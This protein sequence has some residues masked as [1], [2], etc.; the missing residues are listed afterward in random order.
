MQKVSPHDSIL[1]GSDAWIILETNPAWNL[2]DE[3]QRYYAEYVQWTGTYLINRAINL[4]G[5]FSDR[6]DSTFT[7]IEVPNLF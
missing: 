2:T 7:L 1:D 3:T 4:I 6:P 5:T